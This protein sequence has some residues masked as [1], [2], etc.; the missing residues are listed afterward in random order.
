LHQNCNLRRSELHKA[1]PVAKSI[2]G[3]VTV[4]AQVTGAS[5]SQMELNLVMSD[6]AQQ[7][8][9]SGLSMAFSQ[10][11]DISVITLDRTYTAVSCN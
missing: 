10:E 4:N 3:T 8:M 1:D 6:M 2:S 11:N 5:I 7:M 9:M